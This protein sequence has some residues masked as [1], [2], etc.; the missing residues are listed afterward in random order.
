MRFLYLTRSSGSPMRLIGGG[1]HDFCL[2][3]GVSSVLVKS[4]LDA[5]LAGL[6]SAGVLICAGGRTAAGLTVAGGE[7]AVLTGGGGEAAV[8]PPLRVGAITN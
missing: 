4:F 2:R 6:S 1:K 7:A 3:V 5:N 8:L